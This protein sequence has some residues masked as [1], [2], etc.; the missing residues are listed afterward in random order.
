M[1]RAG[2]ISD[3]FTDIP[4]FSTYCMDDF[5][6]SQITELGVLVVYGIETGARGGTAHFRINRNR[7]HLNP[8][9][10][11][12]GEGTGGEAA[13]GDWVVSF[14]GLPCPPGTY[15]LEFWVTRDFASQGQWLWAHSNVNQGPPP[16]G[17]RGSEY[18]IQNP[19]LGRG[20]GTG[21]AIPGSDPRNPAN[22]N[23]PRDLAFTI[24]GLNIPEPNTFFAIGAGLLTILRIRG[25]RWK[26]TRNVQN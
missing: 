22:P 4:D 1:G 8:D 10:I 20:W 2:S 17:V 26:Y 7:D 11:T 16:S 24:E 14:G 12:G 25:R 15:W 23:D 3:N 6:L 18:Y 5:T 19:G 21:L 13:N 9:P